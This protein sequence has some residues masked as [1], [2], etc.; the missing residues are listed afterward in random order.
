MEYNFE[1]NK[2]SMKRTVCMNVIKRI[3]SLFD[4]CK[5]HDDTISSQSRQINLNILFDASLEFGSN[6]MRPIKE[7]AQERL[8]E[9]TEEESSEISLYI[10]QVRSDINGFI[11]DKYDYRIQNTVIAAAEIK[12]WIKEN[13]TWMNKKNISHAYSQGMYYAWHG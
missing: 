5:S 9:L 11:S 2:F 10:E 7:L 8:P 4:S 3:K 12:Q 13:Y 1:K 6:W